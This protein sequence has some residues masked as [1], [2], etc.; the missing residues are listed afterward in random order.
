MGKMD[1]GAILTHFLSRYAGLAFHRE[2]CLLSVIIYICNYAL[3]FG[4]V[5]S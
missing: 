2:T 3:Y 5:C 4:S 1:G